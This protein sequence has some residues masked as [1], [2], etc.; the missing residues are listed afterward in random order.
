MYSQAGYKS[1]IKVF[2]NTGKELFTN[3]LASTYAIDVAISNDNKTLAV[4]EID[5]NGIIYAVN[6][7]MNPTL[8]NFFKQRGIE[9]DEESF[10]LFNTLQT[11]WRTNIRKGQDII[12]AIPIFRTRRILGQYIKD[13]MGEEFF[14]TFL[15]KNVVNRRKN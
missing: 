13:T 1:L 7:Y 15:A 8:A 4:A 9:I 5:A 3:Y 11:I 2:S 10:S 6:L 14:A 12:V